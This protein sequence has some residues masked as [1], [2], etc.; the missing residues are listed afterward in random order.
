MSTV[1]QNSVLAFHKFIIHTQ[2][3]ILGPAAEVLAYPDKVRMI[4]YTRNN[5][6][7]K[8]PTYFTHLPTNIFEIIKLL[9]TEYVRNI[10][11]YTFLKI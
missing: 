3:Y 7:S 6:E 2:S 11:A 5:I 4:L 9:S 8:E 1:L 10:N